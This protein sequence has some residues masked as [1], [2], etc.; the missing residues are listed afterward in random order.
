MFTV[1]LY[2]LGNA[3]FYQIMFVAAIVQAKTRVWSW[4]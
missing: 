1:I 3:E 4:Y 2:S